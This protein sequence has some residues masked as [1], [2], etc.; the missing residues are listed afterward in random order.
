MTYME[1][2]GA[3]CGNCGNRHIKGKCNRQCIN[4]DRLPG[5]DP[6]PGVQ[7]KVFDI[8]QGSRRGKG[9]QVI[10]DE[11]QEAII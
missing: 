1:N 10:S 4:S 6:A 7:V 9:R 2:L 11:R 5:W 3:N 8:S